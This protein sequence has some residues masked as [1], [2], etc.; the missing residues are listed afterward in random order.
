MTI[1]LYLFRSSYLRGMRRTLSGGFW[2]ISGCRLETYRFVSTH[3]WVG[4]CRCVFR[5]FASFSSRAFVSPTSLGVGHSFLPFDSLNVFKK[6]PSCPSLCESTT[7]SVFG[8]PY[9]NPSPV[10]CDVSNTCKRIGACK[11]GLRAGIKSSASGRDVI[12][13]TTNGSV[14]TLSNSSRGNSL[15]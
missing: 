14:S 6:V 4:A 8:R 5:F 15:H 11:G 9:Q 10:S 1:Q 3:R 7:P 2:R 12:C 13:Q